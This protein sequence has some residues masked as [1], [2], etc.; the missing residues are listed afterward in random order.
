MLRLFLL[1]RSSHRALDRIF[2]CL[3]PLSLGVLLNGCA[4]VSYYGQLASGQWQLLQARKPVA[5]MLADPAT[6]PMLRQHLLQ[7][8]HAR[9]FASE[10]LKLPDN[11][12]YRVYA[13]LERPFV[14]WNV[15][16]TPEFS[17]EPKTHCFPIAGCVAYRGFYSQ[18]AARGAAALQ[19]Q[20][21][22]DVYIGGVEAYSTLGWFDD[23]ILNTML[24]WG[25][26]RL[27]TVI[28]HE[29]AHQRFYVAD[30]TAFNE[31]FAT[32]VEQE[33]T[34]QW[35]AARGLP[36]QQR[37]ENRQRDQ[38]VELVLASRE[39]LK[40]LYASP[41][42][43]SAKRAGKQAE[44]E[45]LRR[46]Y[47]AMRDTQW[48]GAGRYDGWINAP[49][50]NAKLLPFGLYDQWVPAFAGLFAQVSGDWEVFYARVE[51]LGRL[52]VEQRHR[53][54]EDIAGQAGSHI[55]R[56]GIAPR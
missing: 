52:P 18:G 2:R 6:P 33:G 44:F 21:G 26:E 46:E 40:A 30:D 15:F 3:V 49:M 19:K 12:S 7:A 36:P 43:E 37:D 24:R 47:R 22:L 20:Q 28:F 34:R 41:L 48:N 16:A 39:R 25:D 53:Q 17:L 4:S 32:F 51:G 29:L 23:P 38:F 13:D 9:A 42:T 55:G 5:D 56:S 54:L 31:S 50:N 14:V 35:R 8:E 27:A 10:R 45:R 1:L 11:R